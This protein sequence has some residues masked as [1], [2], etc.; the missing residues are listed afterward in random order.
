MI[1]G[2]PFVSLLST[3]VFSTPVTR[4]SGL[5]PYVTSYV[6]IFVFLCRVMSALLHG[7]WA[8]LHLWCIMSGVLVLGYHYF[9]S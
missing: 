5:S 7:G 3:F 9:V 1:N 2:E 8:D 4:A 6:R